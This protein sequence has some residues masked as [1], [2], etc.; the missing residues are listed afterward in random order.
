[1]NKDF[2]FWK[3]SCQVWPQVSQSLSWT[4]GNG[5]KELF[6]ND[7]QLEGYDPLINLS[8]SKVLVDIVDCT[9]A[10]MIR[11]KKQ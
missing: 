3:A 7:D 4:L 10:D 9:V 11:N 6:W 5:R 2:V 1:M 8:N